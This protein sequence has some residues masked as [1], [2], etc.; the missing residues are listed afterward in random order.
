MSSCCPQYSDDT[1]N[2]TRDCCS[3]SK[4]INDKCPHVNFSGILT[5]GVLLETKYLVAAQLGFV[6]GK[7]NHTAASDNK[8]NAKNYLYYVERVN[9]AAIFGNYVIDCDMLRQS[10]ISRDLTCPK[11]Y[12]S[13]KKVKDLFRHKTMKNYWDYLQDV[14]ALSIVGDTTSF[15]STIL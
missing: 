6:D 15:F 10:D 8:H 12:S 11:D 9:S 4:K 14:I 5:N 1:S 2:S 7:H 13:D 3:A